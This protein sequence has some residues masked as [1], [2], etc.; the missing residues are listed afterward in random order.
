MAFK[1]EI[2]DTNAKIPELRSPA[3][4]EAGL[5]NRS[6]VLTRKITQQKLPIAKWAV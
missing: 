2:S 1:S 6:A 3:K 4:S 5:F